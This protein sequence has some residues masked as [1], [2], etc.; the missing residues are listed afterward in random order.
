MKRDYLLFTLS[1]LIVVLLDQVSKWFMVAQLEPYQAHSVIPGF[2]DL[3]LVKNKGMAFGILGQSRSHVAAYLLMGA[4]L[5]AILVIVVF[6]WRARRDQK[7]LTVGL[8]LILGGAVGNLVDR[9][10]L[11]FVIDFL[12]FSIK[13]YHWPA[14]NLADSAVTMGTLWLLLNLVLG[15]SLSGKSP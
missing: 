8:A 5:A 11:G 14:F 7:W 2:L 1:A 15:K 9:I 3:V 12:D 10:R 13:G 6:F 4:T